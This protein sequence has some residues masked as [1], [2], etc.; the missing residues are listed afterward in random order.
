MKKLTLIA[1]ALIA[2]AASCAKEEKT[3]NRDAHTPGLT[4]TATI[5]Q[6][7]KATISYNKILWADG[8]RINVYNGSG[9]TLFNLSSGAGTGDAEFTQASGPAI[10]PKGVAVFPASIATSYSGEVATV[11]LPASYASLAAGEIPVPMVAK[12]EYDTVE[13]LNFKPLTGFIRFGYSSAKVAGAKYFVVETD[14]KINGEFSV[15]NYQ[16]LAGEHTA[17]GDNVIKV[18]IPNDVYSFIVPL[19]VGTYGSIKMWLADENESPVAGVNVV[20]YTDEP[21]ARLDLITASYGCRYNSNFSASTTLKEIS[22]L[23]SLTYTI[24]TEVPAGYSY[25]RYNYTV[26]KF[27]SDYQAS[28][29]K[30]MEGTPGT[31]RSGKVSINNNLLPDTEY[32]TIVLGV[33]VEGE[34]KSY[35]GDYYIYR[36]KTASL[37]DLLGDSYDKWIGKWTLKYGGDKTLSIRISQRERFSTYNLTGLYKGN[38]T[39][40]A[41]ISVVPISFS[42]TD[43]TV[44]LKTVKDESLKLD[45]YEGTSGTY[46]NLCPLLARYIENSEYTTTGR[47]ICTLSLDENTF[48]ASVSHRGT[49]TV[50]NSGT[51]DVAKFRLIYSGTK[52]STGNSTPVRFVDSPQIALDGMTWVKDTSSTTNSGYDV[53][54]VEF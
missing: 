17:A 13:E 5:D 46:Q 14:K 50:T 23:T 8:D 22:S 41:A 19:P 43:G 3:Q 18:E 6:T 44:I 24:T 2:L 39:D 12:V 37:E 51:L 15:S 30:F 11:T 42:F 40:I 16:V 7:T 38:N 31:L 21:V 54:P 10:T 33:D 26:A 28:I 36:Y 53:D 35:N 45:T 9:F 1:L 32:V 48:E 25:V 27:E 4:L 49:V 20:E 34:N 52:V 47:E 29:A